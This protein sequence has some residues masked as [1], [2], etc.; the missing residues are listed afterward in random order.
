MQKKILCTIVIFASIISFSACQS[1]TNAGINSIDLN[2]LSAPIDIPI[3]SRKV[4]LNRGAYTYILNRKAVLNS[5]EYIVVR[6]DI[7]SLPLK[8][9]A[10]PVD[11]YAR[12]L[13]VIPTKDKDAV[14]A[15]RNF[16]TGEWKIKTR[17]DMTQA[18][19]M[20]NHF[21][22]A[23]FMIGILP[24][25]SSIRRISKR[26]REGDTIKVSGI[27]FKHS[28]VFR[29]GEEEPLIHCLATINVFYLTELE[30]EN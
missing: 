16:K 5:N 11:A 25:D 18:Q 6:T 21:N 10:A 29:N 13:E 23:E 8:H 17:E 1:M 12:T 22:S 27:H 30:I 2:D 14:R 4:K 9:E 28:K 19:R 15:L 3:S 24:A 26:I 7:L 20:V